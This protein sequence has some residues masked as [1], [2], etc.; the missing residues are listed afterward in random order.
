[1]DTTVQPVVIALM[2]VLE[3][4]VWQVRVALATRGRPPP[5][6]G[7]GRPAER[8]G[9]RS[10]ASAG[11]PWSSRSRARTPSWNA[12]QI[13]VSRSSLM[14]SASATRLL[15]LGEAPLLDVE[16]G[17]GCS[18]GSSRGRRAGAAGPPPWPRA[19]R[20][21]AP[22]SPSISLA[23]AIP[24]DAVPCST[25]S[26][27]SSS[28]ICARLVAR[29]PRLRGVA[30]LR[31]EEG[32]AGPGRS[33]APAVVGAPSR[34][35]MAAARAAR[36]RRGRRRTSAK[37]ESARVPGA[38]RDDLA[39]LARS[40]SARS[41]GRDRVVE[42][43]G[44]VQLHRTG[45][46]QGRPGGGVV[47]RRGAARPRR[48]RRPPGARPSGTPRPPPRARS[49]GSGRRP[50]PP[51][52]GG[53]ARSGPPPTSS[54]A[55]RSSPRAAPAPNRARP[56]RGSPTGRSRGGTRRRR[57]AGRSARCAASTPTVADRHPERGEQLAADRFGCA[58]EQ[59]EATPRRRGQRGDPGEHGVPDA[60]G[61]RRVRLG[62]DL[63]D[64]ERV[65]RG[66]AVDSTGSSPCPSRA[67]RRPTGSAASAAGGTRRARRPGRRGPGQRMV[68]ADARR[69]RTAPAAA[70]APRSGGRG[71]ARGPASPRRPS[72][73]PPP[74]TR[75]D[76]HAGR[77][78][79]RRRSRA[80]PRCR[81]AVRRTD[82]PSSSA[83]S[84]SGPSGRGVLSESHMPH[85]G[86]ALRHPLD[87]G[88]QQ[89]GLADARPRRRRGR[90]SRVRRR[91]GEP[92]PRAGRG[93]A[94][95]PAGAFTDRM[96]TR[97]GPGTSGAADPLIH[98]AVAQRARPSHP[99]AGGGS[100]LPLLARR[101]CR[102]GQRATAATTRPLP[103]SRAIRAAT[104]PA[105][106][107]YRRTRPRRR[108]RHPEA[109]SSRH[110]GSTPG[111]PRAPLAGAQN[112]G[113]GHRHRHGRH[114]G[115]Q[116]CA[117]YRATGAPR[118]RRAGATTRRHAP[119]VSTSSPAPQ[120]RP[121]RTG[122]PRAPGAAH[123]PLDQALSCPGQRAPAAK[124]APPAAVRSR[125]THQLRAVGVR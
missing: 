53:R 51:P 52:R 44:E 9:R 47:G 10:S 36:P 125:G 46:E 111:T 114:A 124:R 79:R 98:I 103:S 97:G 58:R 85:S 102:P 78:A 20:P 73:G 96:R 16:V 113:G 28:A 74:R 35:S 33:P 7:S 29:P 76:G 60:R 50:R 55:R 62:E 119:T 112:G 100:S 65:A 68:D 95:A 84:R 93:D 86:C 70:A 69:G 94:R 88:A 12:V 89:D 115:S 81:A 39:E 30:A 59:L 22:R 83:T 42:P 101:R 123:G 108:S 64:E 106:S 26:S 41:A 121:N 1:M 54:R 8:R 34:I 99:V 105:R 120:G 92:A 5:R 91:R 49:A 4:A 17:R 37:P 3:V 71:T 90:R 24:I 18:S 67:R 117:G 21:G 110:A 116:R 61:H 122:P 2:V 11:R 104:S 45:L 109:E 72:A 57:R 23:T 31:R 19:G 15:G 48:R 27:P 38:D 80:G 13:G 14:R 32:A 107:R 87:E 6:P 43:V 75:A 66:P 40:S 56:R 25:A 63:A 77:R 118:R 82:G